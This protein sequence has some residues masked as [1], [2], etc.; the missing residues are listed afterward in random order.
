MAAA[1]AGDPYLSQQWWLGGA[2]VDPSRG[3]GQVVAVI[4]SGVSQD[5]EDLRDRLQRGADGAVAG[6][7]LVD[8]GMPDDPHG[9]GTMVAGIVA[10]TADNGVGIVGMAPGVTILPIRV[11]DADGRGTADRVAGGVTWAIE[12]GATVVNVSLETSGGTGQEL[13]DTAVVRRAIASATA[14]GVPVV[15]AAGNRSSVVDNDDPLVVVV[16]AHDRDGRA[17]QASGTGP[18]VLFA[19]GVD[20]VTT[21]CPPPDSCRDGSSYGVGSGSSFAAPVVAGLLAQHLADG[22]DGLAAVGAVRER[23]VPLVGGTGRRVVIGV[24]GVLPGA[25]AEVMA[26]PD[27]VTAPEPTSGWTPPR[28]TAPMLLVVG[29]FGLVVI[30]VVVRL[31]DRHG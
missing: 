19:P 1:G 15:L 11:L 6:L 7:D 20:M 25:T 18:D 31:R 17:S 12:H 27:S 2:T 29:A 28:V 24:A 4:D 21:W 16:G 8:G 9:H 22:L 5:H 23:S 3:L 13:L 14:A 10:A 26:A 30:N